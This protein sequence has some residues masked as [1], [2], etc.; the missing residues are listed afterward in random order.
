M[1]D[2]LSKTTTNSIGIPPT[3]FDEA[4][5]LIKRPLLNKRQRSLSI[6]GITVN[7]A[8]I[9][10]YRHNSAKITTDMAGNLRTTLEYS[11]SNTFQI[12][13]QRSKFTNIQRDI[14]N[15]QVYIYI[16]VEQ[17]GGYLQS[18]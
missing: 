1:S 9:P 17:I 15:S 18:Q 7:K 3:S 10:Q 5:A 6:G 12:A 4:R 2:P 13:F 16:I 14:L 11:V 8:L